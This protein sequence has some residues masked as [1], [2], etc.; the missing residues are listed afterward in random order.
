MRGCQLF[1]LP[2]PPAEHKHFSAAL[3]ECRCALSKFQGHH[4][5]YKY[6]L[7]GPTL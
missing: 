5:E 2:M 7:H 3:N 1:K 6:F 4:H